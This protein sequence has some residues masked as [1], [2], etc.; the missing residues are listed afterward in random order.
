MGITWITVNL[1]W[2]QAIGGR[3]GFAVGFFPADEYF[4][5][6]ALANPLTHYSNLAFS[7]G[8]EIA[9]PDTGFSVSGAAMI[10]D[11]WYVRGGIHDAN[12]DSTNPNL[13]VFGD[14]ELYKNLE[15]G[16]TSSAERRYH[17]NFHVGAWHV[18]ARSDAG[19]PES[20][21]LV[22]S[23]SWYFDDSRVMPFL[24][25]GWSDGKATLLDAQ[26][27]AGVAKVFRERDLGGIGVS[28]GNPSAPGTSDQWTSE[29][30]YRIQLGNLAITPSVQMI[31]DP[32]LDPAEDV[33]WVGGL[34]SR[35]VF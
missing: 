25:G 14:W 8:G 3:A 20:W 17:D 35:V 24:R 28:W 34:R 33:L 23:A 19:V 7:T 18:D 30:F 9:I 5:S 2:V 32:A 12:G 1:H 15:I 4:Q 11:H 27:S 6:Y 22:G 21:G 13:D 16:W 31:V 26:V 29:L 10:D